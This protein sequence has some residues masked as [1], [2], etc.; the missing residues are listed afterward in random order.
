[1]TG[2]DERMVRPYALTRGRTK[3]HR[4][5]PLEAL[6][7]TSA[8]GATFDAGRTPEAHTICRMCTSSKSVAEISATLRVPLGVTRVLV[9]D[10]VDAGLVVVHEQS[11]DAPGV[12]L[13]ERVLS[14]L[15]KL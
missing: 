8:T 13:L 5:Y 11:D 1:M 7:V 14:G 2:P 10:L 12:D 15:R 9:G 6:V 4:A 3:A